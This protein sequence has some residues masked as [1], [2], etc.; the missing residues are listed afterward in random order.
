MKLFYLLI[1]IYSTPP[2]LF[3]AEQFD[4]F[5]H[6]PILSSNILE[7]YQPEEKGPLQIQGSSSLE[8]TLNYSSVKYYI[9]NNIF[10]ETK[11][12]NH[13]NYNF[14]LKFSASIWGGLTGVPY[15]QA[16]YDAVGGGA[17]GIMFAGITLFSFGTSTIW[18]YC[19][20]L[21][22]YIIK[23]SPLEQKYLPSRTVTIKEHLTCNALGAIASLQFI[24]MGYFF[25]TNIHNTNIIM[26]AIAGIT[27]YGL[28]T[29]GFYEIVP[30]FHEIV[31]YLNYCNKKTNQ[32]I[33]EENI[34]IKN[35]LRQNA[36]DQDIP[37]Q[38][39]EDFTQKASYFN[40]VI[41]SSIFTQLAEGKKKAELKIFL[42]ESLSLK[43]MHDLNKKFESQES[44]N[45]SVSHAIAK[46]DCYQKAF[47]YMGTSY[48]ILCT[49]V[50]F[51][52]LSFELLNL[53]IDPYVC[54]VL[55]TISTI[56]YCSLLAL[57]SNGALT[58]IY[59]HLY[60]LKEYIYHSNK[61]YENRNNETQ[62]LNETI[63]PYFQTVNPLFSAIIAGISSYSQYYIS[64][65]AC[66]QY[67]LLNYIKYLIA[68]GYFTANVVFT[69]Y[70]M[71]GL[72]D[73]IFPTLYAWSPIRCGLLG[74]KE[75]KYIADAINK[76]SVI[77]NIYSV[78]LKNV[79]E[80]ESVT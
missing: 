44:E 65:Q 24:S 5:V 1:L 43:S 51:S 75:V 61:K 34:S 63:F 39:V 13:C 46:M 54:G 30:Y 68:P 38:N 41:S 36:L 7:H 71:A 66:E 74:T 27:G 20:A 15:L 55:A 60:N 29:V 19:H 70:S 40:E 21:D 72:L 9:D 6:N 53:W 22:Q 28:A 79:K 45:N 31:P 57:T 8:D 76:I 80:S 10:N 49:A 52:V 33:P 50:T 77:S 12:E 47:V 59:N 67:R 58:S 64:V 4:S 48:L 32:N 17:A 42:R 18:F 78:Y 25:N 69:G 62:T 73:D 16:S 14:L 23:K 56:P 35:P 11:L 37:N 26:A 2:F 3:S